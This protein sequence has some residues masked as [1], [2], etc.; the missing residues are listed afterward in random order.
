MKRVSFKED[1]RDVYSTPCLPF[2]VMKITYGDGGG[3]SGDDDTRN[4]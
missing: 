3:G 4:K 1:K 2:R